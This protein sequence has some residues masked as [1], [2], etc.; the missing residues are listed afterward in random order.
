VNITP[1]QTYSP[2]IVTAGRKDAAH[3]PYIMCRS[4]ATQK[5]DI[6]PGDRVKV[7]HPSNAFYVDGTYDGIVDPFIEGKIEP[8]ELFMVFLRPECVKQFTHSFTFVP[9]SDEPEEKDEVL[10]RDNETDAACRRCDS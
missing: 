5:Y 6:T 10:D 8:G 4:D 7:L 1:G 3:M 2:Q 9:C